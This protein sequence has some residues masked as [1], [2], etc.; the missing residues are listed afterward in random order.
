VLVVAI[1]VVV[2]C[3]ASTDGGRAVDWFFVSEL[4]SVPPTGESIQDSHALDQSA[5]G[6]FVLFSAVAS[7]G[8]D[9]FFVRDNL[10]ET[11]TRADLFPSGVTPEPLNVS[12]IS[13]DGRW[14]AFNTTVL[15]GGAACSGLHIWVRDLA[16]GVTSRPQTLAGNGSVPGPG[17]LCGLLSGITYDGDLVVDWGE[18]GLQYWSNAAKT[19]ERIDVNDGGAPAAGR[20]YLDLPGSP[21]GKN[22][23]SN[24]RFVAFTSEANNLTPDD[25][26]PGPDL[27]VR[28]RLA[29]TTKIVSLTW[30]GRP[31]ITINS[32]GQH[33]GFRSVYVSDDGNRVLFAT[34]ASLSGGFGLDVGR[35]QQGF[36]RDMATR[37]TFRVPSES[38]PRLVS[39]DASGEFVTYVVR[40]YAPTN[41]ADKIFAHTLDTHVAVLIH[42]QP[43]VDASVVGANVR[44]S[45]DGHR[46]IYSQDDS[47]G[48]SAELRDWQVYT[49]KVASTFPLDVSKSSLSGEFIGSY[50][51]SI[52]CPDRAAHLS[53]F[54][55]DTEGRSFFQP[56]TV[57]L[58]SSRGA[59]DTISPASQ[60]TSSGSA[61]FRVCSNAV[62]TAVFTAIV[63]GAATPHTV[64]IYFRNPP[65][66][67]HNKVL[68]I[69]GINTSSSCDGSTGST[70]Q[71]VSWMRDALTTKWRKTLTN[72]TN[73]DFLYFD[74]TDLSDS[75]Q[76]CQVT[77]PDAQRYPEYASRA[78]FWSLDDQAPAGQGTQSVQGGGSAQ[79][80][81]DWLDSYFSSNPDD[82]ITIVAHSQGGFIAALMVAKYAPARVVGQLRAIVT[83]DTPLGGVAAWKAALFHEWECGVHHEPCRL[84]HDST[85]DMRTGSGPQSDVSKTAAKGVPVL[86]VDEAPGYFGFA[87]PRLAEFGSDLVQLAGQAAHLSVAAPY[88]GD[89]WSGTAGPVNVLIGSGAIPSPGLG[90]EGCS[91]CDRERLLNFVTCAIVAGRNQSGQCSDFARAQNFVVLPKSVQY[92]TVPVW[93]WEQEQIKLL[94]RWPGSTVTTTLVSPSGRRIDASTIAPDVQ[95]FADATSELFTVD[96]PESGTWSVEMYGEDVAAAGEDVSLAVLKMTSPDADLDGDGVVDADDNCPSAWNPSQSDGDDDLLGD[97]CD[98]DIDGDSVANAIDNCP[99]AANP[100]QSD[101]DQNGRGD[102]CDPDS[103]LDTDADG[104]SDGS[105]NC[106]ILSNPDQ[107]DADGDGHGDAC[108]PF[109]DPPIETPTSSPTP[110]STPTITATPTPTHEP[111]SVPT[112]G[113][114]LTIDCDPAISGLQ[115][116]CSP[117]A[118]VVSLDVSVTNIDSPDVKI[119]AFAFEL[120]GED[121]GSFDPL[122]ASPDPLES[123]PNFNEL[124]GGSPLCSPPPPMTDLDPDPSVSVSFIVCFWPASDGPPLRTGETLRLATVTYGI[125]TN[126]QPGAFYL[127]NAAIYDDT[128]TDI[129]S[130][131][132]ALRNA[133]PCIDASLM[134]SIGG[135]IAT[136]TPTPTATA[137][138]TPTSTPT[139]TA[140]ATNT[141]T[142]TNTSS[143][144]ATATRTRTPTP[145]ATSTFT[146]TATRTN[147]PVPTA[148]STPVS[149]I[150]CADVDGSGVVAAND[151]LQI[152]LRVGLRRGETGYR[153]K[154]DL[155]GNGRISAIDVA[156]ALFQLGRRCRQ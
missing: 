95:H 26:N 71:Q 88:H 59:V 141:T 147:S 66:P 124:L 139:P 113:F 144:T 51:Q 96:Q 65:P 90:P 110:S 8:N 12:M 35:F 122:P 81:A 106:P 150:K 123:N 32:D 75:M 58:E 79:R 48:G 9:H 61:G 108:D 132:P 153:D 115:S 18:S 44:L 41:R 85:A 3:I 22:V 156:I 105:D 142:P 33:F 73:R 103:L 131:N 56:A 86:T 2:G 154:Y 111:G 19:I 1:L 151:V 74:Y 27:F 112:G 99:F 28:D 104:V 30:T 24:G 98:E 89:A 100:S 70:Y 45:A 125:A 138:E 80:L 43:V 119:S 14:V 17:P 69:A 64:K 72:M 145:T 7:D 94:T 77:D 63:N 148:T 36:V 42:E 5:D 114:Y 127:R 130:C 93:P 25:L 82:Q 21:R 120:V 102:A 155:G 34:D 11:T 53:V 126:A 76:W 87:L 23:A 68:F 31:L 133:G 107:T 149:G 55:K 121:Q 146:P 67:G 20:S 117:A 128:A 47:G 29:R 57:T 91:Q 134:P 62:G 50:E 92:T 10:Q 84:E 129:I 97:A 152:T 136:L 109:V 13:G 83:I 54:L 52:G 101:V 143:P 78:T 4:V 135:P 140:T 49:Q 60:V 137:T 38:E 46:V 16:T 37:T 116:A 39:M 40:D 6:R 118:S 15:E